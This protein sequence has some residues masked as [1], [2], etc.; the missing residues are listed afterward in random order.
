MDASAFYVYPV[1]RSWEI[2]FNELPVSKIKTPFENLRHS[3]SVVLIL[4][5]LAVS[6]KRTRPRSFRYNKC[7]EMRTAFI[8]LNALGKSY[9]QKK[10]DREKLRLG[11]ISSP[12]QPFPFFRDTVYLFEALRSPKQK[13]SR[14]KVAERKSLDLNLESYYNVHNIMNISRIIPSFPILPRLTETMHERLLPRLFDI[15]DMTFANMTNFGEF[16]SVSSWFPLVGFSSGIVK[17]NK[18]L[19][20]NCMHLESIARIHI[21]ARV[22]KSDT[23]ITEATFVN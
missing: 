4:T 15:L 18:R 8:S 9:S 6:P 19:S 21:H 22:R 1:R 20:A 17:L 13:D 16:S 2:D 14:G 12:A 5:W 11:S 3:P 23:G 10:R 7:I